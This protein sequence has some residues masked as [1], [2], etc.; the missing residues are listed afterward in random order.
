MP[1]P[2]PAWQGQAANTGWLSVLLME[3]GQEQTLAPLLLDHAVRQLKDAGMQTVLYGCDPAHFFPGVPDTDTALMEQLTAFGF[4]AG[5]TAHDLSRDLIDYTL[6]E[7]ATRAL[8]ASGLQIEPCSFS[9]V[10]ALI[11]FLKETFP[12]RWLYDT[13]RRL[14][15]EP[16]ASDILILTDGKEVSGFVHVYH[17][18]SRMIGASIYWREALGYA[19]GGLGPIGVAQNVRKQGL[20]LALLCYA[21]QHLKNLGVRQMAIDWTDL[22]DFYGKIGFTPWRTYHHAKLTL[23]QE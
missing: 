9:L 14:R 5:G 10:P 3:P 17:R 4:Q 8:E 16:D 6:P 23:T 11:E 2:T 19:Y 21:V 22:V 7:K 18:G 13:Q 12:G 1:P 20:G 15:A